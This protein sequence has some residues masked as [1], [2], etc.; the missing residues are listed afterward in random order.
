[1]YSDISS[2]FFLHDMISVQNFSDEDASESSNEDDED[3]PKV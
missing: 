1:M 2:L 3:S